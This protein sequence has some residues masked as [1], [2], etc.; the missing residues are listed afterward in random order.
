MG[1]EVTIGT[2]TF[3]LEE[4]L[5]R[6]I[7]LLSQR[8]TAEH[9]KQDS[10]IA[11]DGRTGSGKTNASLVCAG[12]AQKLTGRT[13]HLFFSSGTTLEYAQKTE[14]QLIILDEPS[15][16]LLARDWQANNAKDF[17]RL[18]N[19]MRRKRH[20]FVVNLANFWHF[21]EHLVVDRLN[22]L[23]HMDHRPGNLGRGVW[24]RSNKIERLWNDYKKLHKR[25]FFNLKSFRFYVPYIMEDGTLEEMDIYVEEKAHA[26][27]ND[28]ESL[29]DRAIA[30]INQGKDKSNPHKV[31]LNEL[32]YKLG[33]LD[34]EKLK[35]GG[36]TK[37]IF[38]SMIGVDSVRLREWRLLDKNEPKNDDSTRENGVL[39][40]I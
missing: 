8:V 18:L 11:I 27:Y 10:F 6:K 32:R 38:A 25:N 12:I 15:L 5:Y 37:Q 21:P 36:V 2:R 23:M 28:Y 22:G 35:K 13:P 9:P 14:K 19:T 40:G 7:E 26:T 20:Y 1:H 30:S 4:P 16:D 34:F 31:K 17:L 3:M 33:T 39:E 29:K 24:I